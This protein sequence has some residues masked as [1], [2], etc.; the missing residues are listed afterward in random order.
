MK[1]KD[2]K[3]GETYNNIQVLADLGTK[4][5]GRAYLCKCMLCGK[6]YEIQ[7]KH[8][9]AVKS[10]K[11]CSNKNRIIDLTGQRFGRLE[12]LEYVCRKNDRTLWKCKCD[13]GN[14]T[15]VGYS[16]LINENTRSCGCMEEENRLANMR[17][18]TKNR[19]KSVSNPIEF[20][21][22]NQHALYSIW[23]SM[24]TRCN[25]SN[26]KSYKH[27]G[28]RG[29]KVCE[30][31]QGECGFE[32]FIKDMGNRPS[33]KHSID[34]IDVNGDYTPENCRWATMKEQASNRRDNSCLYIKGKRIIAQTLCDLVELDYS[35]TTHQLQKGYDINLILKYKGV[36]LR[37]KEMRLIREKYKNYNRVI[38]EEFWH[39]M[40][41]EVYDN[42]LNI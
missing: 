33:P 3:I 21:V 5:K 1:V 12:V 37:T 39:L 2:I 18:A 38:S 11:A 32:N 34:R 17:L 16:N 7:N 20:G 23:S 40:P 4:G 9:G 28:G 42:L 22:I 26:R 19:T 29:I 14:E 8:I 30:R 35:R 13:C 6:E 27:Y 36:D 31:W 41:K 15:I 10:C 24:L 25:N